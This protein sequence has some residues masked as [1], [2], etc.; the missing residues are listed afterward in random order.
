MVPMENM[1]TYSRLFRTIRKVLKGG[2]KMSEML[3]ILKDTAK[4][5]RSGKC[6]LD[7]ANVIQDLGYTFAAV[8]NAE[9]REARRIGEQ[10][11]LADL[12]QSVEMLT[13]GK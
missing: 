12:H 9:D 6:A 1:K 11:M 13:T 3:E 8:M 7:P 10:K 5:V 2:E 4:E